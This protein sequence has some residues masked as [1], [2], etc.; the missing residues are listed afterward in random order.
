MSLKSYYLIK[1][2]R[3]GLRDINVKEDVLKYHCE[4]EDTILCMSIYKRCGNLL[5][6]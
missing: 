3:E 2:N 5:I 6:Y 1:K 4:E